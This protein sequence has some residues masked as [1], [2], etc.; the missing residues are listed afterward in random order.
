MC[1]EG[2]AGGIYWGV[3]FDGETVAKPCRDVDKRFRCV[4]LKLICPYC[5]CSLHP[6]IISV[7]FQ[8]FSGKG[9]Q[10]M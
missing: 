2:F 8:Q 5:D 10:E 3:A 9:V 4:N 7:T 6:K 1:L